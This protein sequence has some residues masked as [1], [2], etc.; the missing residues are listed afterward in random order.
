MEAQYSGLS[1]MERSVEWSSSFMMRLEKLR[2]NSH[3]QASRKQTYK[4]ATIEK[5]I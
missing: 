5:L 4:Q 2:K 1:K 3:N